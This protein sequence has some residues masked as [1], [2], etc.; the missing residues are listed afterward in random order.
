MMQAGSGGIVNIVSEKGGRL[1][2]MAPLTL[3]VFKVYYL[4]V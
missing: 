1:G 3:V 2:L 4:L